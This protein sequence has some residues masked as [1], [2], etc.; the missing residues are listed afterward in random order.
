V[1]FEDPPRLNYWGSQADI[2][3]PP[4]WELYDVKNDP[5]EMNNLYGNLEYAGIIAELKNKLKS[6]R[7]D[8]DETDE[9]YP[10]IQKIIDLHWGD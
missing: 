2:V 5:H 7:E 8:L 9:D 6:L 4:G 1:D 3:T 10:H